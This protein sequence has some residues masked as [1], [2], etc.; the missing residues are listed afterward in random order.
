MI[1]MISRKVRCQHYHA[2]CTMETKMEV[3]TH[4]QMLGVPRHLSRSMGKA[5][6][7]PS[8]GVH[9]VWRNAT[10]MYGHKSQLA[11][12]RSERRVCEEQCLLGQVPLHLVRYRCVCHDYAEEVG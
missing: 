5:I 12:R 9:G 1:E 4:A 3:D 8:R 6:R 2:C 7:H 11:R 10:D